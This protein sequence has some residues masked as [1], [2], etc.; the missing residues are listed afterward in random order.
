MDKI[1][2]GLAETGG[3]DQVDI[4]IVPATE[5]RPRPELPPWCDKFPKLCE[6]YLKAKE[7]LQARQKLR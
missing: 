4:Q 5:G 6:L 1:T 7:R 3:S 2:L